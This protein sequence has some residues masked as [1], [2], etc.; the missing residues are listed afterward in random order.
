MGGSLKGADFS[1][2]LAQVSHTNN[3]ISATE[4]PTSSRYTAYAVLSLD[5]A[6]ILNIHLCAYQHSRSPARP[7]NRQLYPRDWTQPP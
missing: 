5:V 3:T 6:A 7:A 2:S 1:V 4:K